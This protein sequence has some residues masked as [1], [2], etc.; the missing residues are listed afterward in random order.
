MSPIRN[1]LLRV[2]Y[3]IYNYS[4]INKYTLRERERE[5][6]RERGERER[7]RERL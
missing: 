7:E 1:T 4:V 5:R 3:E 6:E 2:Q